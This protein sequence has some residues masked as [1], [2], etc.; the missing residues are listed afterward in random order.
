MDKESA[1]KIAA[2]HINKMNNDNTYSKEMI[3]V[4]KEP[5]RV[6][7]GFYFNYTYDSI[8]PEFPIFIAGAPGF[9]VSNSDGK[10]LDLSWPEYHNLKINR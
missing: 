2:V 4:L 7:K 1:I 5:I 10:I 9:I 6:D 8:N 3:W